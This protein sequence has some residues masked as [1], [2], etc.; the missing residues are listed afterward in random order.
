MQRPKAELETATRYA[1]L[2]FA[3]LLLNSPSMS[4]GHPGYSYFDFK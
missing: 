2:I 4:V 3:F 1:L